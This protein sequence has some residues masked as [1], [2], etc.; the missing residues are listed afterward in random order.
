MNKINILIVHPHPVV[1]NALGFWFNGDARFNVRAICMDNLV[2]LEFISEDGPDAVIIDIACGPVSPDVL[3]RYISRRNPR[4]KIVC[5]SSLSDAKS[6]I[7]SVL[8]AGASCFIPQD[9]GFADLAHSVSDLTQAAVP[10]HPPVLQG[11]QGLR[12]IG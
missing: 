5:I 9:K 11:A 12:A 2:G 8:E 1:A 10:R 6:F 7:P 4:I 3:I